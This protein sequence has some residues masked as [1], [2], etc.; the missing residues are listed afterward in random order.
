MTGRTQVSSRDH[1]QFK[2]PEPVSHRETEGRAWRWPC[3][4]PGVWEHE[5]G[6]Q[7]PYKNTQGGAALEAEEPVL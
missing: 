6:V 4:L 2:Y 1:D 3:L 7:V 5:G